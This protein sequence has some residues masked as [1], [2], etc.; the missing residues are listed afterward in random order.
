MIVVRSWQIIVS[1]FYYYFIYY[2]YI[3]LCRHRQLVWHKDLLYVTRGIESDGIVEWV[4]QHDGVRHALP[5]GSYK[6]NGLDDAWPY[7]AECHLIELVLLC[8]LVSEHNLNTKQHLH[9]SFP[10]KDVRW[11]VNVSWSKTPGRVF[12][13]MSM[14][15][16]FCGDESL[17]LRFWIRLGPYFMPHLDLIDPFFLQ[18]NLVCLDHI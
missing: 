8:L 15:G 18:K 7:C 9:I 4:L 12:P 6:V 13:Y 10:I 1:L 14:V 11:C 17:V 3:W 2:T 16:R 5:D